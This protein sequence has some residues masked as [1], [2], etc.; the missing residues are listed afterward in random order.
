MHTLHINWPR[1]LAVKIYESQVD[2]ILN[3]FKYAI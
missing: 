2:S 1:K 3:I